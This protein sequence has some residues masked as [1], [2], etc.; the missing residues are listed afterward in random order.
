MSIFVPGHWDD[1]FFVCCWIFVWVGSPENC[2]NC[3]SSIPIMTRIRA[4]DN[5]FGYTNPNSLSLKDILY[6]GTI[7]PQTTSLFP[8]LAFCLLECPR[9]KPWNLYHEDDFK[10]E[11][12]NAL[13]F[14][15]LKFSGWSFSPKKL[16]ALSVLYWKEKWNRLLKYA[17]Y[18]ISVS[19]PQKL[20][21][22]GRKGKG[23]NSVYCTDTVMRLSTKIL[24]C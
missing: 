6:T 12:C 2:G 19:K 23:Q 24:N 20:E 16:G 13:L 15:Y 3:F 22:A 14:S 8:N 17:I 9:I 18:Q 11:M 1:Q 21:G 4:A 10:T 5:S 7:F